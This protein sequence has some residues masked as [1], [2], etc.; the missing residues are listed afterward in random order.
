MGFFPS[1]V[2]YCYYR[3]LR[4]D[5]PYIHE[6]P[7]ILRTDILIAESASQAGLQRAG[8]PLPGLQGC[9]L[10]LLSCAPPA[11]AR[12][13]EKR[14]ISGAPTHCPPD[15]VPRTPAG[16]L[17]SLH[18]RFLERLTEKFGM[19]HVLS[20]NSPIYLAVIILQFDGCDNWFGVML[21]KTHLGFLHIDGAIDKCDMRK[22]LWVVAQC[23]VTM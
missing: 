13:R 7:Q 8:S 15:S 1:W 14:V 6:S 23:H 20:K 11:A 22:G 5:C 17:R 21:G 18:S 9:P 12:R 2:V 19:T 10:L 3:T 4:Y 16:A